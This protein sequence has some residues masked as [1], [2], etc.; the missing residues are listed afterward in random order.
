MLDL[1]FLDVLPKMISKSKTENFRMSLLT[2]F[3]VS[4]S[5]RWRFQSA[6]DKSAFYLQVTFLGPLA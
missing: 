2:P 1:L 3:E 6:Y 5:L 4:V